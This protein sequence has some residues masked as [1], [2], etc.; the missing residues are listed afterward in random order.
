MFLRYK[1]ALK[2]IGVN[3]SSSDIYRIKDGEFSARCQTIHERGAANIAALADFGVTNAALTALQ[4]AIE[5]YA[6]SVPKPRS[7]ITDRATVKRNIKNL[8]FDAD[9][10]LIEQMDKLVEAMSKTQPDFAN[11]YKSA[12]VIIDPKPKKKSGTD[13]GE[14][15]PPA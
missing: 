13:N 5:D 10:I 6:A 11:T 4:A 14:T 15:N 2:I 9:D 1:F 12:R 7:A 3:F 8:F